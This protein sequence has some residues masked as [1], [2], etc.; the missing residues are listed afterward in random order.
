MI[1]LTE[2]KGGLLKK[3]FIKENKYCRNTHKA[4]KPFFHL[5]N[6]HVSVLIKLFKKKKLENGNQAYCFE[7]EAEYIFFEMVFFP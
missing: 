7:T 4:F 2:L 3:C 1:K 5:Q 6:Q